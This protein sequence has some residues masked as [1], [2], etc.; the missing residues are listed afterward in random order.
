[1]AHGRL[2]V[3]SLPSPPNFLLR[4]FKAEEITSGGEDKQRLE[5]LTAGYA[6]AFR[7][8]SWEV[9]EESLP[10]PEVVFSLWP[11]LAFGRLSREPKTT[12]SG[13]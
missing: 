11:S 2:T 7:P 5:R 1:M 8:K 13:T 4:G 10:P 12:T 3:N 9:L 6:L